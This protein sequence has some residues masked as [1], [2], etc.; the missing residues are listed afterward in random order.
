MSDANLLL[1]SIGPV[2]AMV[3]ADRE[4]KG[5]SE[6]QLAR[7]WEMRRSASATRKESRRGARVDVAVDCG[8]T[9]R[10]E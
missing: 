8:A 10:V 2:S 7:K 9:L 5:I 4:T 6:A 3:S 1:L